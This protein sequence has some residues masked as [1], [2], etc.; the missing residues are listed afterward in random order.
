MHVLRVPRQINTVAGRATHFVNIHGLSVAAARAQSGGGYQ[1][2]CSNSL[3]QLP[4]NTAKQ[5]NLTAGFK[6]PL[7]NKKQ[8]SFKDEVESRI[9]LDKPL[10]DEGSFNSSEEEKKDIEDDM[11]EEDSE[12]EDDDTLEWEDD[13]SEN[14]D[15][16][17][18]PLLHRVD[19]ESVRRSLL[20]ETG[21]RKHDSEEL[22]VGGW[23]EDFLY[24][25]YCVSSATL[26]SVL[27]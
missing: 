6:R 27:L 17:K 22:A 11:I 3:E 16:A 2:R 14:T 21:P 4:C 26:L 23:W 25:H 8:L 15:N 10:E 1:R 7:N 5:S 12:E 9:R 20:T 24:M 13:A 18:E 19:C